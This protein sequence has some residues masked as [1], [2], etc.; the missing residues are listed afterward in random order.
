MIRINWHQP[1]LLVALA[2]LCAFVSLAGLALAGTEDGSFC[3]TCPDW[4]NP[5]AWLR[6]KQAYE[7]AN[8]PL[9]GNGNS[10]AASPPQQQPA[11]AEPQK[12]PRDGSLTAPG[13][14]LV[15]WTI[16]DARSPE[17][18]ARGHIP[19]ARNLY[20]KAA[21][22]G[23]S[24]KATLMAEKLG[25]LGVSIGDPILV[26]GNGDDAS[27]LFWAL[28]YLGHQNLSRL[29]GGVQG[30][31]D[32][33]GELVQNSPAANATVY[34]LNVQTWRLAGPSD[35]E[36]P[37]VQIVDARSSFADYGRARIKGAI[38]IKS[39]SLYSD[40]EAGVLLGARELES[41]LSGRGLDPGKLQVV[42]GMPAA[43][44][45]YYALRLMD[46][47]ATLIDGDWWESLGL[48]EKSIS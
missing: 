27:Y 10:G 45:V 20:W 11:V 47:N 26:Y 14:D 12:Y 31:L 2:I 6:Q 25:A 24:L 7:Q 21:S 16:L 9:A 4:T 36:L 44:T 43:S 38:Q 48:V 5:D 8:S 40:P 39:E 23:G 34:Q 28:E 19:G 41:L 42:Y 29:D 46:Y 17:D 30:Y 3:P 13:A 35:L 18:Y 37:G 22:T 1:G 15:G 32:R 33:G